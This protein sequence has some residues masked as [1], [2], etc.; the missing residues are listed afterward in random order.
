[1]LA[2]IG[3]SALVG[4]VILAIAWAAL[5]TVGLPGVWDGHEAF[6]RPV[7]FVG[8]IGGGALPIIGVK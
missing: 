3:I 2:A 1:M 7:F 6:T 4:G 8:A 5:W